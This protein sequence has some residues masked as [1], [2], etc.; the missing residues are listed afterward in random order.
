ML[1]MFIDLV[2]PWLTH[3]TMSNER[4]WAVKG[5]LSYVAL[6]FPTLC[7]VFVFIGLIIQCVLYKG[8]VIIFTM[9]LQ[10]SEPGARHTAVVPAAQSHT[11]GVWN[12]ARLPCLSWINPVTQ[13]D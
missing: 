8:L 4:I 13:N 7:S 1:V 10:S 2:F 11:C 6:F 3:E 12:L 9:F 5:A